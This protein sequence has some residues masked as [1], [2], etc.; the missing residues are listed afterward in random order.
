MMVHLALIH[1]T[2]EEAA[3]GEEVEVVQQQ[4]KLQ[5]VD[6]V[7]EG[8]EVAKANLKGM[9][10]P[11]HYCPKTVKKAVAVGTILEPQVTMAEIH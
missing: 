3:V 9:T 6:W 1:S 10:K 7:G 8:V 4:V 2:E 11:H 5:V